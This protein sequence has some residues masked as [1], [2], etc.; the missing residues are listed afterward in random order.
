MEKIRRGCYIST[1]R[2]WVFVFFVLL[3]LSGGW[4][5]Q[6][7]AGATVAE[8]TSGYILLQVEKNGEAWYVYPKTL[9]R[10]YLGRPADAFDIMRRLG[11]GISN[12][13]L[14]K[15]PVAGSSQPGDAGLRARLSGYI[16]L[17]VEKNGEAWYVYPKNKQ[18]YYLGR[19]AD[20]Y[21]I[22]RSLGLG[23]TNVNLAQIPID[24]GINYTQRS[25]STNR[26]TYTVD[27][28]TFDRKNPAL[29]F[30]TDTASTSNC[31]N[32]CPVTSL[33]TYVSRRSGMAGIH[34]TYFCPADYASCAGQVNFYYFPVYNSDAKVMINGDRI[35]FTTE[36]IVA[37]DTT[38]LP[39]F[40]PSTKV[41]TSTQDF[42]NEFGDDARA[43][44]GTGT[45]RAAISN[46]PALIINGQNVVNPNVLDNKQR[47]VKSYRGA[48]GWKGDIYYLAIVRGATVEDSA[49][50]M[51]ALNLDNALNL[52]GG[53]STAM[54]LNGRYIL[55]P[56][57]N[58][59]NAIGI[60]PQ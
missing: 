45:L 46:G 31:G 2:R 32:N 58:L 33:G 53:G 16:L 52:D 26:G 18:R 14:A 47:T 25:V 23:I 27:Y 24:A 39:I 55:G 37:V 15:I 50:V 1:M 35:K 22:M 48:L 5:Y 21:S 29:K 3:L 19:P 41:F 34:G 56:G 17:Q 44:G 20:A 4:R 13:N 10:F 42:Y 11:L 40:Y 49:A 36:P 60:A 38:N 51:D 43:L 8:R 30:T 57:R 54:Y 6:S 7:A 59:P 12:A 9:T 28:L